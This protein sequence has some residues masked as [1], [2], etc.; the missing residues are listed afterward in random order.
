SVLVGHS[1]QNG[2]RRILNFRRIP[3]RRFAEGASVGLR[4]G[5]KLEQVPETWAF[6][7][8]ENPGLEFSD[9][10]L[11][12]WGVGIVSDR[13]AT[14]E[15]DY[16]RLVG[17]GEIRSGGIGYMLRRLV[18][19]RARNAREGV[20]LAGK[21]VERFGYV[22]TGR[23]Y[24][25]ADPREAWVVAVVRGRR[26]VAQRVP[27]D[28]VVI[29]PNVHIIG[30]V[31]L[32]DTDHFLASPDLVGYAARR[33]WFDPGAGEPFSFR[34]VYSETRGGP[35]D[36]RRLRGR[37][38]VTGQSESV[39][40]GEGLSFGVRP[41]KKMTVAAVVEILRDTKGAVPL[42]T[43]GTQEGTVFQLRANVPREVGCVYWRT[44]AE[45]AASVLTP[46]YLGIT[47]TPPSYFRSASVEEHMSLDHH[48]QPP[49]GTF[50]FDRNLAWWTF[51]TLQDRVHQDYRRRIAVVATAWG[52]FE[53]E[54]FENQPSVEA[55]ALKLRKTDQEA[56]RRHLTE[57]CADVAAR[58]RREAEKMIGARR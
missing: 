55:E 56:A 7:W 17:R 25:I 23:S 4:R 3:R 53:R 15:D 50:D 39:S 5:G 32:A 20:E 37:E 8:S 1:E 29:L 11:N 13:C 48:F 6:L 30:Q 42:S 31:D 38:L 57:Y 24:V 22:D 40:P 9:A 19:E 26:W 51:K 58:A 10:Y 27:D 33:G 45:P 49:R 21:L 36:P 52:E 18:A 44:T 12:E 34:N 47:E 2:G 43:P 41:A 16:Q 35:V 54:M 46:W 28:R 14:R